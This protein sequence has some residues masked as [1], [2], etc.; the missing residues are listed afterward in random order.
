MCPFRDTPAVEI[1]DSH[2]LTRMTMRNL[3]A[4]KACPRNTMIEFGE[5]MMTANVSERSQSAMTS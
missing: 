2:Q 3:I 1:M 4:L 5:L